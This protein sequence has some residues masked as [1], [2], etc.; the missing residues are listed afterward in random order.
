MPTSGRMSRLPLP[1]LAWPAYYKPSTFMMRHA[2]RLD[3]T[4]FVK[5]LRL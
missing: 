3:S 5:G 4:P 1:T 2:A